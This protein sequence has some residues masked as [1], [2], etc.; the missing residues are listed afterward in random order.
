MKKL[1]MAGA[2]FGAADWSELTVCR[3]VF[4]SGADD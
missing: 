1:T 2:H 3:T 4:S